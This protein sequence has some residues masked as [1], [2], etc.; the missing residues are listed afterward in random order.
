[1]T[2]YTINE[3]AYDPNI[4]YACSPYTKSNGF[5]ILMRHIMMVNKHPELFIGIDLIIKLRPDLLNKQNNKGWTP[6]ML[7][8]RNSRTV[9]SEKVVKLL[10]HSRADLDLK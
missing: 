7:A 6:L 1:M 10:I 5:N 3:W 4:E 2:S 9:S 8:C